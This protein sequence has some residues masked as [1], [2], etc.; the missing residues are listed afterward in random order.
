[1]DYSGQFTAIK[2]AGG[3]EER[4]GGSDRKKKNKTL[5]S[6]VLLRTFDFRLRPSLYGFIGLFIL[7]GGRKLPNEELRDTCQ[8]I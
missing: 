1:M 3:G 2:S 5:L 6:K 4:G 8:K 7:R